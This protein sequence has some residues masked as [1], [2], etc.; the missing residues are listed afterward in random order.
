MLSN[1]SF[2]RSWFRGLLRPLRGNCR[3]LACV[4]LALGLPSRAGS[5]PRSLSFQPAAEVSSDGIFLDQILVT[6][7]QAALPHLRVVDPPALGQTTVLTRA[8]MNAWITQHA[9]DL[10]STNWTG[11]D[12]IRVSR[13]TRSLDEIELR[14]LLCKT[15]QNEVVKSRGELE[16]RLTRPWTSILVPDE[17]LT[18]RI[19]DL[20]A[21]GPSANFI[22]RLELW[23]GEERL[24][25]WQIAA[26]AKVWREIP[27]AQST[28]RRG[29]LLAGSSVNLER[30]DVIGL[31]GD[32]GDFGLDDP[33]LELVENISSGQPVLARSVRVRPV[34]QRGQL[35]DAIVDGGTLTISLKVETLQEGLPG[36]MIRIR[37][38]RTRRELVGKVLNEQAILIPN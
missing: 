12:R 32:V 3:V 20:P 8:Q 35:V 17:S 13:R 4:L 24:G 22:T 28:L 6:T 31:R 26:A 36:Q 10:G 21:T 16:L 2:L 15:L 7:P 23:S 27:V 1:L 29:Q 33:S 18:M 5:P 19:I 11:V 38:P 9:P 30:R 25:N 37:N 34:V 14:E